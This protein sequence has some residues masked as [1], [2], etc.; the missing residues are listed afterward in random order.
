M[1]TLLPF[2]I[3]AINEGVKWEDNFCLQCTNGQQTLNSRKITVSKAVDCK[4]ALKAKQEGTGKT[5]DITLGYT[6]SPYWDR[7]YVR[8]ILFD[9]LSD[10]CPI[11]KCM[12]TDCKSETSPWTGGKVYLDESD[13][14][15]M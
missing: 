14:I 3:T 10:E 9:V 11:T 7:R 8:D 4:Y 1:S 5:T 12:L 13:Q 6:E 15:K 2:K